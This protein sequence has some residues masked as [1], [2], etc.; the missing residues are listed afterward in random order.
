[1]Q[2]QCLINKWRLGQASSPGGG[3]RGG[4]GRGGRG[5][6]GGHPDGPND[7]IIANIVQKINAKLGGRNAKVVPSPSESKLLRVPTLIYGA[8][9]SHAAPGSNAKSIAAVVGN[10]DE[11]CARYVARLSSQAPRRENID[12]LE[13]MAREVALEFYRYVSFYF[14]FIS[15]WA[16]S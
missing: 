15:V 12:D 2:T 9:V 7:Q 8:D 16:T 5:G 6:R 10:T 3:G 14:L 4:G 11:H 13:S 1:M